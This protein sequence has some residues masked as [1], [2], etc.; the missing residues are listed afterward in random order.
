MSSTK[1]RSDID[2]FEETAVYAG[3]LWGHFGHFMAEG[4]HRLWLAFDKEYMHLPIIFVQNGGWNKLPSWALD[5]LR[6]RGL[7]DRCQVVT[8]PTEFRHLMVPECGKVLG[9]LPRPEYRTLL[10]EIYP[11]KTTSLKAPKEKIA[12]LRA[13]LSKGRAIGEEL[14]EESIRKNGYI[15]IRPELIS[16]AE[17]FDLYINAR[18]IIFTE[19]SAIHLLDSAPNITADIAFMPRRYSGTR[20]AQHSLLKN[21]KSLHIFPNSVALPAVDD[22]PGH[23]APGWID[24]LAATQFL[25]DNGFVNEVSEPPSIDEYRRRM[26][27]DLKKFV[28]GR[29]PNWPEN[30]VKKQSINMIKNAVTTLQ[31]RN[32]NFNDYNEIIDRMISISEH[33]Y[34]L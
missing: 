16:M 20:L 13:H 31:E 3:P 6:L 19:G 7:E 1:I 10:D 32:T 5:F 9:Q 26:F 2:I 30:Q 17:Q 4:V 23:A 8:K 22:D 21:A 25:H 33:F 29:R 11:I 18:K 34:I 14:L 15:C 12:V 27:V 24:P 28:A